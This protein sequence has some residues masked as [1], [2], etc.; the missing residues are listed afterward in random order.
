MEAFIRPGKPT[1]NCYIESFNGRLRAE[2][3]N[4]EIFRS[5]AEAQGKLHAWREDFNHRRPHSSIGYLTPLEFARSQA[6]SPSPSLRVGRL[7]AASVKGESALDPVVPQP[8]GLC[9]EG[10][11]QPCEAS[12]T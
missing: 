7:E 11:G 9:C 4:V 2:C 1:E 12:F 10:E 8:L 6:R 3:L 5:M